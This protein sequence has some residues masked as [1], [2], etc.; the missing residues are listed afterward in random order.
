MAVIVLIWGFIF[1][2]FQDPVLLLFGPLSLVKK[3]DWLN[4]SRDSDVEFLIKLLM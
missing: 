2:L 1:F 3:G 4:M